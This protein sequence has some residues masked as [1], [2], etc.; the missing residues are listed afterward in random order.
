MKT[1]IALGA[2]AALGGCMTSAPDRIDPKASYPNAGTGNVK[3]KDAGELVVFGP[4]YP[5]FREAKETVPH[6][7]DGY[8]VYDEQGKRVTELRESRI[9]TDPDNFD[10]ATL[11]PGRYLVRESTG[12]EPRAFWVT[13]ERHGLT[14]VDVD[15]LR[16]LPAEE[17][18]VAPVE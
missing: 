12:R 18:R 2:F 7:T 14:A 4:S 5:R 6:R 16:D 11:P 17:P 1:F 15:T 8:V 10:V 9:T 13:V 3:V